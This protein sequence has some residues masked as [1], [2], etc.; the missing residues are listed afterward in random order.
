MHECGLVNS[1]CRGNRDDQK[2]V[3]S[4]REEEGG[5]TVPK[6]RQQTLPC[7]V[8]DVLVV[9]SELA[10]LL[11]IGNQVPTIHQLFVFLYSTISSYM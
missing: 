10:D 7:H 1:E 5:Y 3:L 8:H 6:F 11:A 4:L 2:C 9:Y